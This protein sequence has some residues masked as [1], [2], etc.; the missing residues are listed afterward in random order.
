[1]FNKVEVKKLYLSNL[2]LMNHYR[3]TQ[4]QISTVY[5]VASRSQGICS[6]ELAVYQDCT[7]QLASTSLKALN[8]KGYLSKTKELDKTGG[9]Y[10]IF[11]IVPELKRLTTSGK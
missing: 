1:M 11:R 5:F 3:L 9:Y 4:K 8:D 7:V 6:S 10:F 2:K